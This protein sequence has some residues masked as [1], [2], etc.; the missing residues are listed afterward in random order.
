MKKAEGRS[1][2]RKAEWP[3]VGDLVMATVKRITP[4]GAYVLLD[5]YDKEGLLHISE[6]SSTWIRNIRNFVREGQKPVLKVLRVDARKS[7]IDVSLRRVSGSE[8]KEKI[9]SWKM[10]RKAESLLRST[11]EKLRIPFEEIYEKAGAIIEREYGIYEGLEKAARD[12]AEILLELGIAKDVA[13]ALTEIARERIKIRVVKIK[14]ILELQCTKPNGASLIREALLSAK[15]VQR[16]R[17]VDVNVYVVA[18]PRY[19]IEVLAENYKEAE[20]TLQEAAETA[21]ENIA[22]VGGQGNFEREK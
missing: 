21:L 5:E 16:P 4:Y 22:K 11:S 8:R 12:G 3:E 20:R 18:V 2:F 9:L 17:G 19:R 1:T 10:D 14:G 7:H 15:R 6:I 13:A